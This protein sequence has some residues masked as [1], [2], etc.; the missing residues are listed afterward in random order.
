M[1]IAIY[2]FPCIPV[3]NSYNKIMGVE[4]GRA[5]YRPTGQ[6]ERNKQ[7]VGWGEQDP[8]GG[9]SRDGA[10]RDNGRGE[11]SARPRTRPSV[12]HRPLAVDPMGLERSWHTQ[13]AS[14]PQTPWICEACAHVT[15]S[16][17]QDRCPRIYL[18]VSPS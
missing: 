12:P 5:I 18:S 14:T 11:V 7:G 17:C 3:G 16:L 4:K 15:L 6:Q 10:V 9:V 8:S 1:L 13:E 2:R